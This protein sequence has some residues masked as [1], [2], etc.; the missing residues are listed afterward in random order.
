MLYSYIL[1][2]KYCLCGHHH[3]QELYSFPLALLFGLTNVLSQNTIKNLFLTHIL[4]ITLLY[5]LHEE[6]KMLFRFGGDN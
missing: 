3:T 6:L 2:R 5:V 4:Y 1:R